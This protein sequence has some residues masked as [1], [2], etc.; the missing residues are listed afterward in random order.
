MGGVLR[1]PRMC[2]RGRGGGARRQSQ[3]ERLGA[4]R[5]QGRTAALNAQISA[6]AGLSRQ[7]SQLER[8][9][10]VLLCARG[11]KASAQRGGT[12]ERRA[13]PPPPPCPRPCGVQATGRSRRFLGRP[14]AVKWPSALKTAVVT[15]GE[16]AALL[17]AA[18]V[19]GTS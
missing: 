5:D 2:A 17:S 3:P 11:R 1:G 12:G 18:V 19:R 9:G 14:S 8:S 15:V 10:W 16:G 13:Q 7:Q 4:L 6:L